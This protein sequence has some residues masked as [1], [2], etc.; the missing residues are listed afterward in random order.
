MKKK[1]GVF[2]SILTASLA[3]AGCNEVKGSETGKDAYRVTATGDWENFTFSRTEALLYMKDIG[4]EGYEEM[5]F[6]PCLEG[7]ST[8]YTSENGG[9]VRTR[10]DERTQTELIT[11]VFQDYI[12]LS[13]ILQGEFANAKYDEATREYTVTL[14]NKGVNANESGSRKHYY[15]GALTVS[16]FEGALVCAEGN[17]SFYTEG[18]TVSAPLGRSV[19]VEKDGYNVSLSWKVGETSITLPSLQE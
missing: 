16:F 11:F 7:G 18:Y 17:L 19:A 3:L 15:S 10:A 12:S 1:V 6:A 4:E 8:M 14:R 13:S 9:E 2:L 5:W